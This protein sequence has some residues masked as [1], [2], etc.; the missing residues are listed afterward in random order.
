MNTA[1]H[2]GFSGPVTTGWA[3]KLELGFDYFTAEC[4]SA[5]SEL[6]PDG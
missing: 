5:V 3:M 6:D 4:D 2:K 1:W